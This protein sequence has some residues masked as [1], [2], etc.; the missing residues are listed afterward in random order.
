MKHIKFGFE[1]LTF[2]VLISIVLLHWGCD[3][4]EEIENETPTITVTDWDGNTYNT[5]KIGNQ[6]WMAKNL[7]TTHYANGTEI[8]LVESTS[9]WDA[10]DYNEK[11]YCY[12]NNINY[13]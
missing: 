9:S 10:L 7:K 2:I 6:W 12:Y 5:I 11:A 13:L 3:K 8:T 4:T 1:Y